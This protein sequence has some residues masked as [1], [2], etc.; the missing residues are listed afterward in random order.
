MIYSAATKV[1]EKIRLRLV[2]NLASEPQTK[3][4]AEWDRFQ[5]RLLSW[6]IRDDMNT[7]RFHM[8]S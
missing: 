4:N 6:D 7:E 5:I 3:V 8:K 1:K 2:L